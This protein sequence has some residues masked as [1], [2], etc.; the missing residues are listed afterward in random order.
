MP[1]HVEC[2]GMASA[3]CP[4]GMT[5]NAVCGDK[6]GSGARSMPVGGGTAGGPGGGG[7]AGMPGGK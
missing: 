1:C 6:G 4:A 2:N 7:A 3:D 5:C